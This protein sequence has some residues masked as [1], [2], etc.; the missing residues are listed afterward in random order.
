MYNPYDNF[1]YSNM[2]RPQIQGARFVDGL[3][4][5][6]A[7][8]IPLGSK[9][10]LMD[11][12]EDKFFIKETDFNGVSTISQYAFTKVEDR[13]E[14]GNNYVTR[15]EFERWKENY[16]SAIRRQQPADSTLSRQSGV[17]ADTGAG[18]PVSTDHQD[19]TPRGP[20]PGAAVSQ[21]QFRFS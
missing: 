12:N 16:E 2:Y 11:S 19:N 5:A 10:I 9:A 6:Q 18:S 21:G 3:A 17:S 15:E 7:C 4:G 14:S 20:E 1:V 13:P 8:V